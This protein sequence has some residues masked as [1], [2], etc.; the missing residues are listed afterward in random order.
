MSEPE[1][2]LDCAAP[3]D[4]TGSTLERRDYY[5]VVTKARFSPGAANYII[6]EDFLDIN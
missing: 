4:I 6:P 3:A 1:T 5:E 2:V